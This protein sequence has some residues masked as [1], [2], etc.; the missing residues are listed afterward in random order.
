[1]IKRIGRKIA[2]HYRIVKKFSSVFEAKLAQELLNVYHIK[3]YLAHKYRHAQTQ[4]TEGMREICLMVLPQ[5]YQLAH[6]L[7]YRTYSI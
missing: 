2:N 4:L 5:D 7:L 6:R 1:M 3:T